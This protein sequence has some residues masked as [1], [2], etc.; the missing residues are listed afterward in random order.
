MIWQIRF[1]SIV[2]LVL[3]PSHVGHELELFTVVLLVLFEDDES[4]GDSIFQ[5]ACF[6]FHVIELSFHKFWFVARLSF[7]SS[8]QTIESSRFSFT[9][10]SCPIIP[11]F[12]R[13]LRKESKHKERE[14]KRR[15]N[16]RIFFKVSVK[17]WNFLVILLLLLSILFEKECYFW[18]RFCS[19]KMKKCFWTFFRES[20][21][22]FW[23]PRFFFERRRLLARLKALL[24]TAACGDV[25]ELVKS[26]CVQLSL[27]WSA[28]DPLHQAVSHI[29]LEKED[30]IIRSWR[31]KKKKNETKTGKRTFCKKDGKDFFFRTKVD[32]EQIEK[33]FQED[34]SL[35]PQQKSFNERC[36]RNFFLEQKKTDDY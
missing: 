27:I 26:V 33:D 6:L 2:G 35:L 24:I 20:E 13:V 7:W 34:F 25:V 31:A 10:S 17:F 14:N 16:M 5:F 22:C 29:F 12:C 9:A 28:G 21:K 15:E 36:L 3:R 4:R 30:T 32:E 19:T 11:F 8:T 1:F 23:F 18:K